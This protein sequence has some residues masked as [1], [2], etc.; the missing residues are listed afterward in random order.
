MKGARALT[1]AMVWILRVAAGAAILVCLAGILLKTDRAAQL[2]SATLVSGLEAATGRQAR[3]GSCALSLFPPS[4]RIRELVVA[5]SGGS[6]DRPLLAARRISASLSME[7]LLRGKVA[8]DEVDVDGVELRYEPD[9]APRS[10]GADHGAA[11][12]PIEVRQILVRHGTLVYLGSAAPFSLEAAG[13]EA[14]ASSAGCGARNCVDGSVR[15]GSFRA[16]YGDHVLAGDAVEA[17]FSLD[18]SFLNVRRFSVRGAGLR[19]S[20][21]AGWRHAEGGAARVSTSVAATGA[22]AESLLGDLPISAGEIDLTATAA[23]VEG[24]VQVSGSGTM[25]DVAY[26]GLATA[27]RAEGRFTLEGGALTVDVTARS[28]TPTIAGPSPASAGALVARITRRPDGASEA[29]VKISPILYRDM[30]GFVDRRLPV[31]DVTASVEGTVTWRAG[32]AATLDGSLAVLLEPFAPG[33]GAGTGGAPGGRPAIALT[34]SLE[35][36]PGARAVALR[37]GRFTF[38]GGAFRFDGEVFRDRRGFDADVS[39]DRAESGA[40]LAA[41]RR[42]PAAAD[43]ADDERIA[44]EVSG[45]A[46]VAMDDRGVTANG[47]LAG[48]ALTLRPGAAVLTGVSARTA[49]RYGRGRLALEGLEIRGADWSASA[50][51]KMD[52]IHAEPLRAA[53]LALKDVPGDPI[54]AALGLA[55]MSGGTISGGARIDLDAPAPAGTGDA[56]REISLTARGAAYAGIP[57]DELSVAAVARGPVIEIRRGIAV[58]AAGTVQATGDCAPESGEA[59]L[60]IVSRDLDVERLLAATPGGARGSAGLVSFQGEA[61]AGRAGATFKGTARGAGLVIFGVPAGEVTADLESGPDGTRASVAAAELGLTGTIGWPPSAEAARLDLVLDGTSLERIRPLL[62]AGTLSGLAGKVSGRIWGTIPASDPQGADLTA[63]FTALTLDAGGAELGIDGESEATLRDGEVWLGRTRIRGSG[64]DL[65]I[66]GVYDVRAGLA[67]AGNASGRF[68]AALLRLA[69]PEIEARGTL[70][71]DLHANSE[72][73]RLVYG[74]RMAADLASLAFPGAP[75]PLQAFRATA[76][77]APDGSLDIESV[78][79]NF[80]GGEVAGTGKGQLRGIEVVRS[81][82]HLHGSNLQMTPL[83][84]LT[85]LFDASLEIVRSGGEA[86]MK[87]RLDVVRAI[88]NRELELEASPAIGR[89]RAA[90]GERP[91]SALP[92]PALDIDVVAP[93]DVLVRNNAA[94]LEGSARLHVS[95]TFAQPEITGRISVLDGGTFRFREVTYRT[96][97]GGIDFDDP[98]VVDPL[99]DL[100][101]RTQVQAYEITLRVLGRYSKPR[102]E[103]TSQPQLPTR[104][105]VALLVTGK[106]YAE[107]YGQETGVALAAE[108]NV[109]QYL[110]APLTGSLSNTVGRVLNLTSVQIEPQ[111]FNGR[112]DPTARVTLTKRV[113]PKLLFVYSDSLGAN[114]EQIYQFQYDLSRSFQ[115]LGT[116]N[117]DGTSSGD[118]RFRHR[119][120]LGARRPKILEAAAGSAAEGAGA[121]FSRGRAE[122][123]L[124]DVTGFDGD[125][126]PL[127]KSLGLRQGRSYTRGDVL[128]ARE[129]LRAWLTRHSYPLA[130]VRLASRGAEGPGGER[131]VELT[132]DV[133]A[134]P[135]VDTEV[136]GIRRSR[137][138]NKVI[139]DALDGT[140]GRDQL[141]AAGEAAIRTR[142]GGD[143]Y[144]TAAVKTSTEVEGDRIRI[145]YDVDRGPKASV[146]TLAFEGRT[147]VPEAELRR[148]METVENRWNTTGRL[149]TPALKPD[150]EAIRSVYLAHGFLDAKVDEPRILMSPDRKRADVTFR[151]EEGEVWSLHEVTIE[152][153]TTYPASSLREATLLVPG[154]GI[155]PSAVD[156]AVE[157]VRDVLDG[158]GYNQARVRSRIEGPPAAAKV[159]LEVDEGPR[160][161]LSSISIRGNSRTNESVIAR[162]IPLKPGDPISRNGTLIAQRKLYALGIFRSIDLRIVPEPGGGELARLVVTVAEGDPLLTAVGVGYNTEQSLQEF[163]QIGHDNLFGTGRSASLFVS[164]SSLQRR[165]QVNLTDRRLFGIPFEGLITAFWEKDERPSFEE[166]REGGTIQ[167]KHQPTR[168]WTLLGRYSVEDVALLNVDPNLDPGTDIGAQDVRLAN[169]AGSLVHD[170]RDDILS[171]ARGSFTTADARLYLAAV[172]SQQQFSRLF[173]SWAWFR[174]I[175]ERTVFATS[176]RMGHEKPIGSTTDIPLADRF[177][178]GGDTTL[179]GFGID[180]AGP[181]D[182]ATLTPIGGQFSILVNEELRFPILGGLKGVVFYDA[183]NVFLTPSAIRF[184]GTAVVRQRSIVA[185]Q[186]GFRHTL[187]TGIRFDTPLGP[188][189]IEYGRKL[190]PKSDMFCLSPGCPPMGSIVRRHESR[191]ELFLSV[192]QAF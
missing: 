24:A 129:M 53:D 178:A 108:E 47:D 7:E 15:A 167:L 27:P 42:F 107:T 12:D 84:D 183:G 111:F 66:S 117:A 60:R 168:R 54:W 64:T 184:T 75:L 172:G 93:S 33:L 71:I 160:Q 11:G 19:G 25:T 143:G 85:I 13:I 94:R 137:A 62:P 98:D 127:K 26:A 5:G 56:G 87:G 38:P 29:R 187:G 6:F 21:S 173:V 134:G 57:L 109:G 177:F 83:P 121:E 125:A 157:R 67:G 142:L 130:S 49:W 4:A 128:E 156:A 82:L 153:T 99:L 151:I 145:T 58:S 81:E 115:L 102:F 31:A 72:E 65:T 52:S 55:S 144:A 122:V 2:A 86:A 119:W 74:G 147:A 69:D 8:V 20:G 97:G 190:D 118:V 131:T 90:S 89:V 191:Y 3:V 96:E 120:G 146:R 185:V 159:I 162:E 188:L 163:A 51:L 181:L 92:S 164:H 141:P 78:A 135:R 138:I 158:N 10:P 77:A 140:A 126:E 35:A 1:S 148:V 41:L 103:L 9:S 76:T 112:A 91:L 150:A 68:D 192:G 73:G 179:R 50:S 22:A 176:F 45:R 32:E 182:L 133:S 186:D 36:W 165:A 136:I 161:V 116:R 48:V 113:S 17:I 63:R 149:R 104:D 70:E 171:P 88:Y 132:Y 101:A 46:R 123:S 23:V 37:G 110:T 105:V 166:R 155:R 170:A 174:S 43:L 139:A 106:T 124:L 14:A 30:L 59:T 114:Q 154:S 44:G 175:S 180:E 18:P 79:F 169:V 16:A 80:A 152:G 28:L 39:I 34:G 40:V 95:G 100:T 189:R 61:V